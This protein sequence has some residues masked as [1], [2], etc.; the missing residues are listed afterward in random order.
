MLYDDVI[1]SFISTMKIQ[2]HLWLLIKVWQIHKY[3]IKKYL[4]NKDKEG[5]NINTFDVDKTLGSEKIKL[6]K[7]N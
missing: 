2:E 1:L 5:N 6:M 3:I 4:K 7:M